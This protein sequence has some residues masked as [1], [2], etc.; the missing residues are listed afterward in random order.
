MCFREMTGEKRYDFTVADTAQVQNWNV[1][2]TDSS[3]GFLHWHRYGWRNR[4]VILSVFAGI[5][6]AGRRKKEE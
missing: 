6:L 4:C 2:S 1:S 5:T 3:G